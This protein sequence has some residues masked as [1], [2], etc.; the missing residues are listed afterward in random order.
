MKLNEADTKL[1][2]HG[3]RVQSASVLV[4]RRVTLLNPHVRSQLSS[5]LGELSHGGDWVEGKRAPLGTSWCSGMGRGM[6]AGTSRY[7]V[8][9]CE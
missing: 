5:H 4:K 9:I 2:A 1:L 6:L 7:L 8:G 3:P